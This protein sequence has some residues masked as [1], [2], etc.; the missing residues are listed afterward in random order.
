MARKLLMI[1]IFLALLT[2]STSCANKVVL[3]PIDKMDIAVMPKGEAYTPDRD[4][5]FLSKTYFKE[6]MD[7]K[8]R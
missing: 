7:A 1:T 8:I 3:H 4:G 2:L 5:F 6:V